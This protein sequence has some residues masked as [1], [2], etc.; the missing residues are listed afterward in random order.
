MSTIVSVHAFRGGTGKSNLTANLVGSMV[1]QGRRVAL[2]DSDI[3]SPGIHA[4]FGL[5]QGNRGH[6]LNDYL[7]GHCPIEDVAHDVTGR[8]RQQA[9]GG[10]LYLLPSS[11]DARDIAKVLREGYEVHLLL[12]GFYAL[13]EALTL[14]YLLLDTHPGLDEETLLTI[15]I[16]DLLLLLLRPDK[17]D[18]QG[19]AVTLEVVRKL[20]MKEVLLVVNKVVPSPDGAY[21]KQRVQETYNTPVAALLPLS[22]EMVRMG[23][24]GL[25]TQIYPDHPYSQGVRDVADVVLGLDKGREVGKSA[26]VPT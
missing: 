23:S 2:V 9:A 7:Y 3:Q 26:A 21:L 11:I 25:F 6:T 18:F 12:D 8:L 10:T 19:T 24:E 13:S 17:Q 5:D 20:G 14:D 22:E 16:S 15:G 1:Q 4:L